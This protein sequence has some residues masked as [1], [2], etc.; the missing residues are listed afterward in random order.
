MSSSNLIRWGGLAAVVGALL[1]IIAELV[2]LF[3]SFT[4]GPIAVVVFGNVVTTIAGVA[5]LLG[6]VALYAQ[7]SEAAGI[8][9]LVAFL[10]AFA[11]T[12]WQ[13]GGVM[14]AALLAALGWALL[15]AVSLRARVYPLAASILLIIGA[16]LYGIANALLGIVGVVGQ[17]VY[18]VVT[19]VFIII[20][21]VFIGWLGSILYA[22]R[23]QPPTRTS[24]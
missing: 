19:V 3:F 17:P 2:I 12:V 22:G 20:F 4:Q 21:Y 11:G 18:F 10:I 6:L 8:P 9:G 13:Q 15:G 5:L 7:E 16:V 1:F 24:S 23:V 14:G